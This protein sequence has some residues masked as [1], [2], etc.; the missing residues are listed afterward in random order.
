ML[1]GKSATRGSP[2]YSHFGATIPLNQQRDEPGFLKQRCR[3]AQGDLADGHD[4][5]RSQLSGNK[6]DSPKKWWAN[7]RLHKRYQY[8][9]RCQQIDAPALV[10]AFQPQQ[11][12]HQNRQNMHKKLSISN[13]RA[14]GIHR[15]WHQ[16]DNSSLQGCVCATFTDT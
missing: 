12:C 16:P 14:G 8:Q 9:S 3:I 1:F 10:L 13:G 5:G 7:R 2:F 4:H 11:F 6:K 15:E